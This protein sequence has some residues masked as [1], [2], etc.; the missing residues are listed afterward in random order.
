MKRKLDMILSFFLLLLLLPLLFFIGISL[1]LSSPKE[2]VIF[3]QKRIG[4]GGKSFW[5][6]KFRSFSE[7]TPDYVPAGKM[8]A[9]NEELSFPA[10]F[11]KK[12]GLDELP[13]LINVLKGEMSLVGPRPLIKEEGSIHKKRMEAGIYKIRPG[14][15]GLAQIHG[16]NRIS[17]QEKLFWD[18]QYLESVS[19]RLDLKICLCTLLQML[20]NI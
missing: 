15:T 18:K 7:K 16:G 1:K 12:S 9:E 17:D 10:G 13:Q 11:L 20:K 14:I 8:Q 6:Y 5:I 4:R 3:R 19:F 2:K